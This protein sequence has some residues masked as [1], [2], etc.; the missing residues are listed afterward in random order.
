MLTLFSAHLL[1][2]LMSGVLVGFTLGLIGGG[3]SILAVPLMVYLVGVKNPH[4]AIG[5][6]ALAVAINALVGLA[7]HARNHTVK[8]RCASIFASCGIA[9]AFIGAAF[10]KTID[11]KKLLLFFALLMIGVGILMLRGRHNVGC[12]GAS[13]NRHNAPKVMGYGLGTGLLSGFFGIGGGF[14]IVPGLIA[15][16]GMPILNAVG[17]SLVA[18]SAFAV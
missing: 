8:W 3:G 18:V 1:L 14:L 13:C 4:V 9:G 6:S 17:T 11:G 5:T 15:S 7:Q 2:E 16:T 10:G 12:Q